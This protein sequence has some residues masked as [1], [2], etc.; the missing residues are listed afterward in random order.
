MTDLYRVRATWSGFEGTPG[1]S[2]L[3]SLGSVSFVPALRAYFL[4]HV[5]SLP[6]NLSIQV[7]STGDIID[8]A[9]GN[10]TGAWSVAPVLPVVGT[11]NFGYAA[12]AG[13]C[14]TWLTTT[15]LDGHRVK[16]RTYIV[17][18]TSDSYD[19]DGT[20]KGAIVTALRAQAATFFGATVGD[21]VV[22]H[23]PRVARPADGSRRAVTARAGGHGVVVGYTVKDNAAILR[24]RRD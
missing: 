3:Y 17:P 21:L 7:E 1:V 13:F 20:I 12:P 16:G 15:I 9:T 4:S 8:D 24:S 14:A 11:N 19:T 23:R 22:W 18:I 2:T 5:A 6:L 10:L